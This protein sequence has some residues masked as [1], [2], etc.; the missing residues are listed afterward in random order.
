MKYLTL[1]IPGL[2]GS[3]NI[4][5][6]P[7]NGVPG[8]TG[9]RLSE[10]VSGFLNVAFYM[11]GFLMLYWLV[12]GIFQYIFAGGNKDGLS[13]ARSRITWAIVGFLIIVVSFALKEYVQTIFP[14]QGVSPTNLTVPAP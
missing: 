2:N 5:D 6:L 4:P 1:N 10:I 14:M 11:A 3:T 7:K 12:W 9:T 13:K 8:F